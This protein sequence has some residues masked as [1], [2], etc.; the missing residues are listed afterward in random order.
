MVFIKFSG[1]DMFLVGELTKEIHSIIAASYGLD[2]EDVIFQASDSFL[3]HKGVDQTSFNLL[4]EIVAPED[5]VD[6]EEMVASILMESSKNY[7][8]H[9]RILFSYYDPTHYYERVNKDY[10]EYITEMQEVEVDESEYDEELE[11]DEEDLY[12]GNMFEDIEEKDDRPVTLND[13]FKRK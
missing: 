1:L 5:Y 13:F 9:V 12:T 11:Y 2:D 3:F 6:S 7:S 4:V 8:V 10:P